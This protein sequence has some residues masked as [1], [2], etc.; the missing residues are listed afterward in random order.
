MKNA[1]ILRDDIERNDGIDN[2]T[3]KIIADYILGNSI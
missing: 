3:T 1:F 2:K